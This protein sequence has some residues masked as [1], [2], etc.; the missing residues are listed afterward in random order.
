LTEKLS[1]RYLVD[2]DETRAALAVFLQ[3]PVIG[4][5][6][7]TFN[8][9]NTK[10]NR[11]SLLQLAAPSGEV[12]VIDGLAAGIQ[13]AHALIEHPDVLMAA[14][15][16]RFDDGVLRSEGFMPE[17]FV[18]TLRLARRTLKLQSFSLASV[19]QHLLGV[20]LDKT[21]QQSNWR[22]RPLSREQLDYAAMDAVIALRVFQTLTD[23]LREAG[24]LEAELRRARLHQ[25]PE[26][27]FPEATFESTRAGR[28]FTPEERQRAERIK[29]WRKE[30]AQRNRIPLYLICQDRTIEELAIQRPRTVEQLQ[31]IHGLGPTKI[32]KYGAE[33]LELLQ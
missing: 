8:D 12:L 13:L 4:L 26:K 17:G 3:Q 7:E 31:A 9:F 30:L 6:T 1:Y 14:H 21:Y 23:R 25:E 28:P 2:P 5:D 18:D 20:T 32:G 19:S 29:A 10:Q 24:K 22:R 11:L 16:A 27:D 33:I 15:N